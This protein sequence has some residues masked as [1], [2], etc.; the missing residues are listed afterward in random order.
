MMH[1]QAKGQ[2]LGNN[3][4]VGY[5]KRERGGPFYLRL[6]NQA[7]LMISVVAVVAVV[8]V[9]VVVGSNVCSIFS[10]IRSLA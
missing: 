8:V 2:Q 1:H 10:H 6:Q 7:G 3:T 4:T 5:T 9:V